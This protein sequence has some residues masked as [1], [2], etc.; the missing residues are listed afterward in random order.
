MRSKAAVTPRSPRR[1]EA[2]AGFPSTAPA[3]LIS[4]SDIEALKERM[5]RLE[6]ELAALKGEGRSAGAKQFDLYSPESIAEYKQAIRRLAIFNDRKPL[7]VY[8]R[9]TGGKVPR[10]T[11]DRQ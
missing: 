11:E 10:T 3:S 5:N 7:D 1:P 2:G 9:K 8:C 6:A 4:F